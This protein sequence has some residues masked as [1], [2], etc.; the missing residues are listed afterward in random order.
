MLEKNHTPFDNMIK[1]YFETFNMRHVIVY[2]VLL[3]EG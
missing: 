1:T 3:G 2:H